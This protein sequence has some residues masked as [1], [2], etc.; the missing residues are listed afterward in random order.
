IR[1]VQP[2]YF[3]DFWQ[4]IG[5]GWGQRISNGFTEV[6]KVKWLNEPDIRWAIKPHLCP[7]TLSATWLEVSATGK[8]HIEQKCQLAVLAHA[9]MIGDPPAITPLN[10]KLQDEWMFSQLKGGTR[11]V[12]WRWQDLDPGLR[13]LP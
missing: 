6:G 4:S 7:E 1:F 11:R 2:F 13:S 9:S 8:Q 3:A 10:W 5:R 12:L